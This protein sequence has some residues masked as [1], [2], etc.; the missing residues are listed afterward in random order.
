MKLLPVLTLAAII[1]LSSL[2]HA[3]DS[4]LEKQMQILARGT[5]QLSAQVNDPSRQ[6]STVTLIESLRKATFDSQNL[7]PRKTTTVSQ[8]DRAP[9]LA[10]YKT[11]M[12]KLADTYGQIEEA[13]KAGQ[14]DNAKSLLGKLGQLKKEGHEKFKQD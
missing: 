11:Q 14:Y 6:Q 7:E 8:T 10:A 9:F 1:P 5:K 13:V 12:Q 2:L 3:E 4:P